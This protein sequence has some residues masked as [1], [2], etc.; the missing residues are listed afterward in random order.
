MRI[1]IEPAIQIDDQHRRMKPDRVARGVGDR[2]DPVILKHP[3]DHAVAVVVSGVHDQVVFNFNV[4]CSR[5]TLYK[6]GCC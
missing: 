2:R 4:G 1:H 3:V 6:S 5:Y